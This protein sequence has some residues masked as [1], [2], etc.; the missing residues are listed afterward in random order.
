MFSQYLLIILQILF[1]DRLHYSFKLYLYSLNNFFFRCLGFR[2]LILGIIMSSSE[3]ELLSKISNIVDQEMGLFNAIKGISIGTDI[4]TNIFTKL[5]KNLDNFSGVQLIASATSFQGIASNLYNQMGKNQLKS[6]YVTVDNFVLVIHIV[7]EVSGAAILDR[8][9]AELEGVEKI[10]KNLK[11]MI[12]KIATFV[13]T[14]DFIKDD[15]FVKITQA[16]PSALSLILVTKE[17]MPIKSIGKHISE[18]MVSSMVAALSNITHVMLKSS[19]DYT[20]IEGDGSIIIIIQLDIERIL[21]VSFPEQEKANI[22]H[23]LALIKV[24]IENDKF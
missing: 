22:G 14:S 9:L 4:A 17:G 15:L 10:Q 18:L 21:A 19:M 24:I 8:K 3:I 1:T 6:T 20:I 23:H 11:K 12:M 7:K 16:L 5:D 2:C 13:E